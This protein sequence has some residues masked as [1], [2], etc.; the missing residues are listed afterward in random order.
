M[1]LGSNG[2]SGSLVEAVLGFLKELTKS[3]CPETFFCNLANASVSPP[4]NKNSGTEFQFSKKSAEGRSIYR[5]SMNAADS[6]D[7]TS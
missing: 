2:S 5:L 1:V 4:E 3:T 7:R 6:P